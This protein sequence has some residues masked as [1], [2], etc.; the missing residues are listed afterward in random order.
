MNTCI[1]CSKEIMPRYKRCEECRKNKKRIYARNK[2][3]L[4]GRYFK[5]GVCSVCKQPLKIMGKNQL[6]HRGCSYKTVENY[7]T[8]PRDKTGKHTISRRLILDLGISIPQNYVVHHVNE[9]PFD[10]QLDNL[11]LLSRS[12]HNSLHGFLRRQ[13]SLLLKDSNSHSENCWN[14]LRAQLTTAWLEITGANVIK[15]V[16]IVQPAGELSEMEEASETMHGTPKD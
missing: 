2:Y 15:I 8:I 7:N 3:K 12:A 13:R 11:W 10:N 14:I 4:N 9:N 6:V 1:D 5:W 16:E